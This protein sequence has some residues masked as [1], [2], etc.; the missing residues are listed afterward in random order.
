M[1]YLYLISIAIFASTLY[2]VERNPRGMGIGYPAIIGAVLCIALGITPF[3]DLITIW[4]IV[5]NSTFTFV[6]IVIF[7][8]TLDEAGF[9]EYLAIRFTIFSGG[10]T[11]LLFVLIIVFGA[12]VSALFANDGAILVLTPVVY[13]ILKRTKA[14][15]RVIMPFIM[16]V[17]FIAD[18]ASSPFIISNLVNIITTSFFSI[19]FIEYALIMMFPAFVSALASLTFLFL[20]YRKSLVGSLDISAVPNPRSVI[21]DEEIFRIAMPMT[22]FL[23]AVYAVTGIF[24]IPIAFIAVP[25]VSALFIY[26]H[27]NRKINTRKILIQAP[28]QVVYFSLG[29]FVIVFGMG[30]EGL[31]FDLSYLLIKISYLGGTFSTVLS[32][33]LFSMMAGLLNNLPSVMIGNLAIR[34][35][36]LGVNLAFANVIGNDIGPKFTPIGSL[37]TL[38]WIYSLERKGEIRISK[39]Y[40]MKVGFILTVPVLLVTLL[41]LSLILYL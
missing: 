17:G 26:A 19:S 10:N 32:G 34:G 25:A 40:Y 35:S 2:F 41:A 15:S 7:S 18:T 6:A 1:I 27:M 14:E 29:M 37:A 5:W 16:A 33:F 31:T 28:W 22:L 20:Y 12:I 11:K 24:G 21:K 13:S 8:L 9:F 38:L 30:R 36:H 3:S 23:I 4:D 39:R